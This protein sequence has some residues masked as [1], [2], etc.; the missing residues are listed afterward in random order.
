M[1]ELDPRL[2]QLTEKVIGAAIA[3]HRHF[4][5]GFLE[6]TY[7]KALSIEL[8]H[9]QIDH[10]SQAPVGLTYRGES[11]GEGRLDLLVENQLVVELKAVNAL[12]PIHKA[13]V[14]SYLKAT[15]HPLGLLINFNV[16]VLRD[17]IRRVILSESPDSA[18][19]VPLRFKP[20]AKHH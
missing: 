2:T 18:S 4:G 11:V 15:R 16:E 17:W 5:P 12:A 3:V 20:D 14:I 6:S 19:S 7:Q 9:L 13:Q 8:T 1:E 10:V